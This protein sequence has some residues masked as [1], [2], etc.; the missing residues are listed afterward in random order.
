MKKE[1]LLAMI[2]FLIGFSACSTYVDDGYYE[3]ANKAS[4][5][6]LDKLDRDY[7]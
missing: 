4:E 3:R 1:L 7:K 5:K 6:S 2:L